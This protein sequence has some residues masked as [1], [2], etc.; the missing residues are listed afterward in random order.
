MTHSFPWY[1]AYL[2][3][4]FTTPAG[5][6]YTGRRGSS[7]R[8]L[9]VPPKARSSSKIRTVKRGGEIAATSNPHQEP[10]AIG[11]AKINGSAPAYIGW[12]TCAYSP[13]DMTH[14]PRSTVIVEAANVFSRTTSRINPNA[15]NM[16]SSRQR[17][18][19]LPPATS[20]TYGLALPRSQFRRT[21]RGLWLGLSSGLDATQLVVPPAYDA[22][23]VS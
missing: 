21:S 7:Y 16:T 12:R 2:G 3:T 17:R 4:F 1:L 14:C 11:I 9:Q 23:L 18:G 19:R 6:T 20:G 10:S 15:A 22:P 13:V 8:S 5:S